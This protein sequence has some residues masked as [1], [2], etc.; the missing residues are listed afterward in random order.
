MANTWEPRNDRFTTKQ[1]VYGSPTL[2]TQSGD[3]EIG[4]NPECSTPT[5]ADRE[6]VTDAEPG[7]DNDVLPA[8]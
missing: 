3:I 6:G 2:A 5:T 1:G 7:K 4:N 8:P